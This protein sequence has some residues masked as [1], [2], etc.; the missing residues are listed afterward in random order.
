MSNNDKV[1]YYEKS[2]FVNR[3]FLSGFFS[4][5]NPIVTTFFT[6]DPAA[7]VH[8]DTVYIFTGHDEAS[9]QVNSSIRLLSIILCFNKVKNDLFKG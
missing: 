1:C 2:N 4:K 5:S 6:A 9:S 3:G 7:L 8:N